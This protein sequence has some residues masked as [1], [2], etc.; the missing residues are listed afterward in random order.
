MGHLGLVRVPALRPAGPETVE[1]HVDGKHVGTI[2]VRVCDQCE[3]A[4]VEGIRMDD[5]PDLADHALRL[6][7]GRLPNHRWTTSRATAAQAEA[8][9]RSLPWWQGAAGNPEYCPHMHR[10]DQPIPAPRADSPAL[11]Q[12]SR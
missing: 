1:C 3:V 12:A 6:L 9:W 4:V 11:P 8:F 2:T 5:Q 7:V 10:S